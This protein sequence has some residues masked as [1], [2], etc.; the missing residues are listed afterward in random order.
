MSTIYR[1][2]IEEKIP[3]RYENL[4]LDSVTRVDNGAVLSGEFSLQLSVGDDLGR[5]L[6]LKQKTRTL[7]TL[8]TPVI[9]EILALG[10]I[11]SCG[12][13]P[14]DCFLFYTGI[15]DFIFCRDF[16]AGDK[17]TGKVVQRGI[18]SGFYQY[19]G[20]MLSS[21]G[22]LIASGDMTAFLIKKSDFVQPQRPETTTQP[23]LKSC[24]IPLVKS[25]QLKDLSLY[26]ID[27]LVHVE[28]DLS[29]LTC[30]YTYPTTH[31]LIRGHFPDYA[32]MMGVMQMMSIEDAGLAL[33]QYLYKKKNKSG[34]YS[35][36][37]NAA[38]YDALGVLVSDIRNCT[39]R[40]YSH[41]SEYVNQVEMVSAGRVSFKK[42]VRPGDTIYTCLS[43]INFL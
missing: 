37:C 7:K 35:V 12:G 9:M 39:L 33:S 41:D 15:K 28:D 4:L 20:E 29:S 24:F 23:P 8:I 13:V 17:I 5:D 22:D 18:K 30:M 21:S 34:I 32:V 14:H 6:F 10:S 38:I 25:P 1:A 19:R 40:V 2:E 36:T 3:H 43:A 31:R 11:V 42:G 16:E 27:T 26:A